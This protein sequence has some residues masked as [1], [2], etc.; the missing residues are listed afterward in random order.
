[1]VKKVTTTWWALALAILGFIAIT[2][3]FE[4]GLNAGKAFWSNR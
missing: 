1:M 2:V 4:E 3:G